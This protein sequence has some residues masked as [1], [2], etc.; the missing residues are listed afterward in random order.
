MTGGAASSV[1][2]AGLESVSAHQRVPSVNASQYDARSPLWVSQKCQGPPDQRSDICRV[3]VL[4]HDF[5]VRL[6]FVAGGYEVN[7]V[8]I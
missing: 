5:S 1:S 7:V 8:Y 6:L 3:N 4:I 2:G